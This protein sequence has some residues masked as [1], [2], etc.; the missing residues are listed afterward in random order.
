MQRGT[1]LQHAVV[2]THA[3]KRDWG[4]PCN[5]LR[6]YTKLPRTA[7]H[8]NTC[9]PRREQQLCYKGRHLRTA[10]VRALSLPPVLFYYLITLYCPR[11]PRPDY[12]PAIIASGKQSD[13]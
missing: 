9:M 2:A 1:W 13:A 4:P 10:R 6:T 8:I 3:G 12:P 7:P 11:V 5:Q